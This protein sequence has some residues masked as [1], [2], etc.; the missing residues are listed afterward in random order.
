MWTSKTIA[1]KFGHWFYLK[2]SSIC[3]FCSTQI[4][5][6]CL[7][8]QFKEHDF[9]P[10][11]LKVWSYV[12]CTGGINSNSSRGEGDRL[13]KRWQLKNAL[14]SGRNIILTLDKWRLL[15]ACSIQGIR[16]VVL[17]GLGKLWIHHNPGSVA[18][19]ADVK[20]RKLQM[21]MWSSAPARR[22]AFAEWED[23]YQTFMSRL[24]GVQCML[25]LP[26][27]WGS[28]I[29][30]SQAGPMTFLPYSTSWA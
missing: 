20:A 4:H 27:A 22:L 23:C 25:Q 2:I 15:T 17:F 6:V 8:T 1:T 21:L 29:T 11:Q 9:F 14:Q 13:Q 12:C 5:L 19:L 30:L 7:A 18:P 16:I 10:T 24:L 3:H 28:Q 26:P